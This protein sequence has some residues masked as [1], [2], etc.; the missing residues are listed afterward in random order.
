MT[1]EREN[2]D[3]Y[4]YST[5]VFIPYTGLAS[6]TSRHT[7]RRE[8]YTYYES[9]PLRAYTTR[10]PSRVPSRPQR[11]S[12]VAEGVSEPSLSLCPLEGTDAINGRD[13]VASYR[14]ALA[15]TFESTGHAV[16]VLD[17]L[18]ARV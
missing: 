15:I 4:Y 3:Y 12:R 18:R 8:A 6:R 11:G 2:A 17:P 7:P 16:S 1:R 14:T 13:R 10:R 5:R 9:S